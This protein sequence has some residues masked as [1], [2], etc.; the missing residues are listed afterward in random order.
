MKQKSTLLSYPRNSPRVTKEMSPPTSARK[1]VQR[2][3]HLRNPSPVRMREKTSRTS[4]PKEPHKTQKVLDPPFTISGTENPCAHVGRQHTTPARRGQEVVCCLIQ[5]NVTLIRSCSRP[6]SVQRRTTLSGQDLPFHLKSAV[7][8]KLTETMSFEHPV[9]PN[10]G[11]SSK[12][13]PTR[14]CNPR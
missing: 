9:P 12:C 13:Q 8:P 6:G 3:A 14:E 4:I 10:S 5:R 7:D 2:K 1:R 11:S